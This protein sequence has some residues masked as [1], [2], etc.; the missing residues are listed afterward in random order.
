MEQ[1]LEDSEG[2]VVHISLLVSGNS[3]RRMAFKSEGEEG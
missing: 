3:F 2:E 1:I